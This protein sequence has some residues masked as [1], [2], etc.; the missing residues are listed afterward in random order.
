MKFR[1]HYLHDYL[2]LEGARIKEFFDNPNNLVS[3]DGI[4]KALADFLDEILMVKGYRAAY[5][6]SSDAWSIEYT[7]SPYGNFD[8]FAKDMGNLCFISSVF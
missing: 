3:E 7:T 4:S 8:E 1:K 2:K 6:E 5:E